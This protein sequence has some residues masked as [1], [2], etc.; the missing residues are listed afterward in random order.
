MALRERDVR[1]GKG[2]GERERE[3]VFREGG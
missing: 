2:R 1:G 3:A